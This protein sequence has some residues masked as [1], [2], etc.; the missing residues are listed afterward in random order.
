MTRGRKGSGRSAKSVQWHWNTR[1]RTGIC[2]R[3]APPGRMSGSF[4]STALGRWC[5]TSEP[6]CYP[7]RHTSRWD[8]PRWSSRTMGLESVA[9]PFSAL[10]LW[11][12]SARYGG[13]KPPLQQGFLSVVPLSCEQYFMNL[14]ANRRSSRDFCQGGPPPR[15]PRPRRGTLGT[16]KEVGSGDHTWGACLAA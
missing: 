5:S 10:P 13:C 11:C 14:V 6:S 7:C 1:E 8:G 2:G 3:G 12:S 9:G 16:R 4:G 15:H